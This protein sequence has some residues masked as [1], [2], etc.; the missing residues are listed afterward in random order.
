ME[1]LQILTVRNGGPPLE[2]CNR[3][4]SQPPRHEPRARSGE[5]KTAG[6]QLVAAHKRQGPAFIAVSEDDFQTGFYT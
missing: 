3:Q 1:F 6:M 5:D 2:N 4:R